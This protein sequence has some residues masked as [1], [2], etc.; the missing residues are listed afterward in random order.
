MLLI[1]SVIDLDFMIIPDSITLGGL[2]AGLVL[3][4]LYPQLMGETIWWK[5][6]YQS[7]FSAVIS[8]GVL[9]LVAFFGSIIFRKEAMGMGDV[10]LLAMIG[11]FIGWQWGLFSIFAG[12]L[13][14]TLA[15]IILITLRKTDIK[16]QIPF[17][18]FLSLG[19]VL[20][21]FFGRTVV[22]W[23]LNLLM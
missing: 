17:G 15:S 9:Y 16:G 10:K 11:S 8:G 18:P 5:G 6:L 23:Y 19:A 3:C 12:S 1:G 2:A 4:T 22:S 7:F 20:S 21:L 14:G 13:I